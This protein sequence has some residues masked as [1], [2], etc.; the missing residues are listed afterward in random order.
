LFLGGF[1]FTRYG[2]ERMDYMTSAEVEGVRYLYN[3]AQPGSMLI[4][5]WSGAP[6]QFRD[7]EQYDT[8]DMNDVLPDAVANGDANSV[9]Q[10]IEAQ[11]VPRSNANIYLLFTRSQEITVESTTDFPPNALDRLEHALLTSGKFKLLYKNA[12][13]Q[14]LVFSG[15]VKRGI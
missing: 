12:D 6:W 3:V 10:F 15:T 13:A 4:A 11:S 7:I 5:G 14:V 1:L 9:V 8:Y 2:N